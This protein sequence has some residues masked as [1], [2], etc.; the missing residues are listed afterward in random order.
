MQWISIEDKW[1]LLIDK[2][3]VI[4]ICIHKVGIMY[5]TFMFREFWSIHTTVMKVTVLYVAFNGVYLP[6]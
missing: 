5:T 2:I 4:A 1:Y 3:Q 6:F